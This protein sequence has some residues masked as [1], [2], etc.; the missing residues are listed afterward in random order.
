MASGSTATLAI[1]GKTA[2]SS[3]FVLLVEKVKRYAERTLAYELDYSA[4]HC[5]ATYA[6]KQ[7]LQEG[8]EL[9]IARK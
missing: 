5:E 2:R 9:Q 4:Q 1:A 3:G 6:I 7:I 8:R